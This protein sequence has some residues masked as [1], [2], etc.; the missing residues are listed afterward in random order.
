MTDTAAVLGQMD[1]VITVDTAAAHLSAA[2]G[3]P[4]WILLPFVSDWRWLMPRLDTPWYATARLFRQRRAG[5]WR[6]VIEQV[7]G[8]LRQVLAGDRSRL[9]PPR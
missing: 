7:A 5:D 9:F 4:T 2:L 8:E 1:L 3:R 6:E